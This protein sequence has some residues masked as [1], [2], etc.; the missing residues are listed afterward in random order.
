MPW[1]YAAAVVAAVVASKGSKKAARTAANAQYAAI[2]EQ[3]RQFDITQKQMA[4]YREAGLRG[5]GNY[6]KMLGEYGDYELPEAFS[7]GADEFNEYKDPGYEFRMDEGLRAID[8]RM[9]KS[10]QRGS[11][12]RPRA[13]ME[14]GQN[15]ASQEFGAARGRAYQDYQSEVA[16]EA[17][18]YGRS[19]TDPLA[20]YGQLAQMGFGGTQSLGQMRGSYA[21]SIGQN[22]GN[23]GRYQA[24][25]TLGQY[26][27]YAQ[28]IGAMGSYY[29][30]NQAPQSYTQGAP[31]SNQNPRHNSVY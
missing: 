22:M 5:L 21:Q 9:A 19:Y 25:G 6:E 27:A 20:R 7:F 31:A 26:G 1:G 11:G 12:R 4:P 14:L 18:D 28:G 8:R 23:A 10:G 29:S 24:A 16:R 30:Q 13:L 15:L 17:E 2:D 3:G